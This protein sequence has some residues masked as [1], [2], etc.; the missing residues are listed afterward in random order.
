MKIRT[1]ALIAL[2]ILVPLVCMAKWVD[3]KKMWMTDNS[4]WPA[5]NAGDTRGIAFNPATGHV[6]VGEDD[7]DKIVILNADT[8]TSI[9]RIINANAG[10]GTVDPFKI[11]CSDDGYIYAFDYAGRCKLVGTEATADA[12]ASPVIINLGGTV[13]RDGYVTG[14]HANGTATVV[15]SRNATGVITTYVF[16]NSP[17]TPGTYTQ[18]TSFLTGQSN[19][20]ESS[21]ITKDL[22]T[23]YIFNQGQRVDKFVG[24]P[25]TGYTIVA[26]Y[27]TPLNITWR[28]QFIIEEESN[29][30]IAASGHSGTPNYAYCAV[31]DIASN[32][33]IGTDVIAPVSGL[34]G[35]FKANGTT[36]NGAGAACVDPK[37]DNIY[38][39]GAGAIAKLHGVRGD[40]KINEIAWDDYSTDDEEFIEIYGPG[41]TDLTGWTLVG[42][43][44]NTAG[45]P[46]YRTVPL[47]AIPADGYLVVGNAG[48]RNVDIVIPGDGI[49]NGDYDAY[50]LHDAEG[51]V[52]DA[53]AYECAV[54]TG[55]LQAFCWEGDPF[56]AN[57]VNMGEDDGDYAV[58]RSRDGLDTNNNDKDFVILPATPGLSNQTDRG[59][60]PTYQ[61]LCDDV[62]GTAY[63][64]AWW[65]T[66][67]DPTATAPGGSGMPPVASPQGGN[68]AL[69]ADNTGG[70]NMVVF[71]DRATTDVSFDAY[72][73]LAPD[74]PLAAADIEQ[75][76]IVVR[77]KADIGY[78]D[79]LLG[80]NRMK[81]S[82]VMWKF[83][84]DDEASTLSLVEALGGVETVHMALPIYGSSN[85]GW[86]RL[87]LDVH[88][89]TV[90]GVVGGTVGSV[91]GNQKYVG[92]LTKGIAIGGIGIAYRELIA[93]DAQ[94]AWL[95]IDDINIR[96]NPGD[97]VPV[98]LSIYNLE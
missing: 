58:G 84:R 38:F 18:V 73:Y 14:S 57:M 82:G 40:I 86:Q 81:S 8:G 13:S 63:S 43:N 27:V 45:G 93:T 65:G 34:A 90:M 85:T 25:A 17:A 62:A 76:N 53:M 20:P 16:Q 79:A 15:V 6:L 9:S 72:V 51:F 37:K 80:I 59:I 42:Y 26:G 88:G 64:V 10:G 32:L 24:S 92:T 95:S 23:I 4:V 67:V 7:N 44:G 30:A 69:V 21:F 70:G 66:Y 49:Q 41:G 31:T 50:V 35:V 83:Y 29:V 22:S 36:N 2:I 3:V 91:S 68:F 75:W 33:A 74:L 52:V 89:N 54:G 5:P 61:N 77:G 39:C 56:I 11:A 87:R 12:A 55:N 46:A 48:V 47:T 1:L 71:M 94:C 28:Y 78:A 19:E 96:T 60:L 98:E 97:V